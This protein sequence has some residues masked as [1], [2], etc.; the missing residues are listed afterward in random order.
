MLTVITYEKKHLR[1]FLNKSQDLWC[2]CIMSTALN[3]TRLNVLCSIKGD[4]HVF[5]DRTSGKQ[6]PCLEGLPYFCDFMM[7]HQSG[8]HSPAQGWVCL[9]LYH[10]QKKYIHK[11]NKIQTFRTRRVLIQNL[12]LFMKKKKNM[13]LY[14]YVGSLQINTL[15]W[16]A[17]HCTMNNRKN[18]RKLQHS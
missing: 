8:Y 1:H 18:G 12:D 10:S 17:S 14:L 16:T 9:W 15:R 3:E 5:F 13:E 2:S 4:V 6:N 11:W 7:L